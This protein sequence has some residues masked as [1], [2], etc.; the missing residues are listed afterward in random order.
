MAAQQATLP[1]MMRIS[2]TAQHFVDNSK[3]FVRPGLSTL[4]KHTKTLPGE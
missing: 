4:A 3:L 1:L 2:G